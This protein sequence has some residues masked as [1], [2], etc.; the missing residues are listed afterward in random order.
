MPKAAWYLR[1]NH[2]W[3]WDPDLLS[4]SLLPLSAAPPLQQEGLAGHLAEALHEDA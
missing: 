1:S 4:V 2:S 3:A